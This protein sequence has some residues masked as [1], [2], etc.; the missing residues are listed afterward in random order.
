VSLQFKALKRARIRVDV[1]NALANLPKRLDGTYDRALSYIDSHQKPQAIRSLTWLAFS[2][3]S[4][5]LIEL[6]E[7]AVTS[8]KSSPL[9][10]GGSRMFEPEAVLDLLPGL[11]TVSYE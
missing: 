7:A 2:T 5:E 8:R 10:N 9:L 6:A 4:L 3:R 1:T 11:V